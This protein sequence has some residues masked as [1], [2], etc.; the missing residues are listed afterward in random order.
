MVWTPVPGSP[1]LIVSQWLV[2]VPIE[3]QSGGHILRAVVA[4][5]ISPR[6]GTPLGYRTIQRSLPVVVS[7]LP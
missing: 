1:V 6:S 2:S 7:P 4:A 5:A 3:A